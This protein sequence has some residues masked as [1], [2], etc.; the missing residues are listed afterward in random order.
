MEDIYVYTIRTVRGKNLDNRHNILNGLLTGLRIQ[1]QMTLT[2]KTTFD[3]ALLSVIKQFAGLSLDQVI[4]NSGSEWSDKLYEGLFVGWGEKNVDADAYFN[5]MG[6][7][8]ACVSSLY[9]ELATAGFSHEDILPK[10][11]DV[12]CNRMAEIKKLY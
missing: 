12:I 11:N 1:L 9:M 7:G 10:L 5:Q 8:M 4:L 3:G 2:G 6:K